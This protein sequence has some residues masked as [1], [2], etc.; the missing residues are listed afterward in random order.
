[1]KQR[2]QLQRLPACGAIKDRL[3]YF[4]TVSVWISRLLMPSEIAM[5][6]S[7]CGCVICRPIWRTTSG[8][9]GWMWLKEYRMRL[10]LHQP[11]WEALAFLNQLQFKRP[12]PLINRVDCALDFL[13]QTFARARELQQY[14]DE[15]WHKPYHRGGHG[16]RVFNGTTY[17]GTKHRQSKY[18]SYAGLPSR[19]TGGPC[20]HYECR[21]QSQRAV[22][23]L[24]VKSIDDLLAFNFIAFWAKRLRLYEYDPEKLG[25]RWDGQHLNRAPRIV[26]R[27]SFSWNRDKRIGNIVV[28]ALG[29]EMDR[30][31]PVLMHLISEASRWG[32]SLVGVLIP[33]DTTALLAGIRRADI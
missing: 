7:L 21:F 17:I 32:R 9:N 25:K 15:R 6:E 30:E 12:A 22:R 31:N 11:R 27:G 20:C 23:S 5:L 18:V 1:M 33:V 28:R 26:R 14:L 16:V 29:S 8:S 2:I 3:A 24:G 19:H 4:D 10:V 13:T